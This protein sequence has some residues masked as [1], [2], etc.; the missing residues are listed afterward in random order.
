MLQL[1]R[2]SLESSMSRYESIGLKDLPFPTEPVVNPYSTDPRQN[3]AIYAESPVM[4]EIEKFE[5]L[6]ICPDD[7]SNRVRLAYLW[8]KGDQQSGRGMGKTALLRYFRQRINHDWG[9]TEFSNQFSAAV[10]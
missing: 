8:S 9:Y 3:G 7:F 5:N 4:S 10:L 6:L 1:P 2:R